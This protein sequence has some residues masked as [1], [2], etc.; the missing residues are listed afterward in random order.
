MAYQG[1]PPPPLGKLIVGNLNQIILVDFNGTQFSIASRVIIPRWLPSSALFKEPNLLYVVNEG[2]TETS[3]F[4]LT[5][6][7]PITPDDIGF[8][9]LSFVGNA[10][11]SLGG[12][13]MAFNADKTRI[14]ESCYTSGKI[15]VW[16]I[17]EKD[18]LPVLK[19]SIRTRTEN[20][21]QWPLQ[22][23]PGPRQAILDPTG[24]FFII[25]NPG[26]NSLHVMDTL[27][28]K[29]EITSITAVPNTISPQCIACITHRGTHYLVVAGGLSTAIALM[30]MDYTDEII[31]FTTVHWGHAGRRWDSGELIM[32]MFTGLEVAKN[33]R[34][35]YLWNRFP[36]EDTGHITQFILSE[37]GG[38]V[39]LTY[40]HSIPTRGIQPR[41][42]SLSGDDD[43]GFAFVANE[44]G[45]SGLVAFR[46][47][48]ATGRLDPNPVATFPNDLLVPHGASMQLL[49]GVQFVR[50]L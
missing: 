28:D 50:E 39:G 1:Y 32:S 2:N 44:A 24:R 11:G 37:E 38:Q 13:H 6:N 30:R 34:D 26:T 31:R 16:D 22:R 40:V 29:Y 20:G 48:P 33:Q 17:S 42:V 41:M 18:H 8:E 47:N 25:P 35:V 5:P 21:Y 10:Q 3:M 27:D 12:V 14:V 7:A 15:D 45:E 4:K 9:K 23:K 49:R 46:R 19:K 36:G 43:Q